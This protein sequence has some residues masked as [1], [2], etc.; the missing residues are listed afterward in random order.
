MEAEPRLIASRRAA[1]ASAASLRRPDASEGIS[2]PSSSSFSSSANPSLEKEKREKFSS[3]S[4]SSSVMRDDEK[5][6]KKKTGQKKDEVHGFS[7]SSSSSLSPFS[8]FSSFS[9]SF[10]SSSRF[11]SDTLECISSTAAAAAASSN[12]GGILSLNETKFIHHVDLT[13]FAT[14]KFSLFGSNWSDSISIFNHPHH[15]RG[16]SLSSLAESS[17]PSSSS[18]SASP[19]SSS[20]VCTPTGVGGERMMVSGDHNEEIRL[21]R[22]LDECGNSISLQ[23]IIFSRPGWPPDISLHSPTWLVNYIQTPLHGENLLFV[24]ERESELSGVA[25]W[26]TETE[27]VAHM[28]LTSC[29]EEDAEAEVFPLDCRVSREERKGEKRQEDK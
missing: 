27:N 7:S 6:E 16:L 1:S 23:M 28:G 14:L 4:F 19:L 26:A 9:S 24:Y 18:S 11:S 25:G 20:R 2:R 3:S 5:E 29:T 21:V 22:C 17:S 15:H 13:D 8:S 12:Y 10:D